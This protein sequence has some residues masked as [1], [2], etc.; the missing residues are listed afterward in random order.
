MH[1]VQAFAK[2]MGLSSVEGKYLEAITGVKNAKTPMERILWTKAAQKFLLKVSYQ[3]EWMDEFEFFKDPFLH[4]LLN[5]ISLSDFRPDLE[6]IKAQFPKEVSKE[7]IR[8]GLALLLRK[9]IIAKDPKA[10]YVRVHRHLSAKHDSASLA[11]KKFHE[12]SLLQAI[13]A[14][15][16]QTLDE[17]EFGSYVFA[18]DEQDIHEIKADI[19]EFTSELVAKYSTRKAP[20]NRV[21]H[22]NVNLIG[23]TKGH[24]K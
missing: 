24:T 2:S 17:R 7:Q 16:T 14:I 6:W 18:M 23:Q 3:V 22:F 9:N 13:E 19:R 11:V 15:Y 1:Y 4:V 12:T 20:K 5:L 21:Y 8:D 10:G